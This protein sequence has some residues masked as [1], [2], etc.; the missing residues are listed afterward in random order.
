MV[1]QKLNE[2]LLQPLTKI[3][4]FVDLLAWR[5]EQVPQGMA[6]AFL[7]GLPPQYGLYAGILPLMVY[8]LLGSSRALAVGPVAIASLMVGSTIA[9]WAAQ[10]HQMRLPR[11]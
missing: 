10:L 2:E 4:T 5:A 1:N 8:A 9:P 3:A 11:S 6:Y 7:A